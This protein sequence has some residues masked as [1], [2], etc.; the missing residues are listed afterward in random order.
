[1]FNVIKKK[2]IYFDQLNPAL[3]E[4]NELTLNDIFLSHFNDS[5]KSDL[6]ILS[7]PLDI[8]PEFTR[9]ELTDEDMQNYKDFCGS[10]EWQFQ[11][12]SKSSNSI[13]GKQKSSDSSSSSSSSL[14]NNN[15]K[16]AALESQSFIGK[17]IKI[18]TLIK[19]KI[20]TKKSKNS[21]RKKR[22]KF[23]RQ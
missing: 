13:P 22:P 23:I 10:Q 16:S 12:K 17:F 21:N 15:H 5:F 2:R 14:I 8:E 11:L 19:L 3:D 1:M 18:F 6:N 20:F 7:T 9:T 4:S